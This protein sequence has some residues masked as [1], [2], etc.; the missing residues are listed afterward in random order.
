MPV[1]IILCGSRVLVFKFYFA[2]PV[3][4]PCLLYYCYYCVTRQIN[5]ARESWGINQV[6]SRHSFGGG[7]S[8]LPH[9]SHPQPTRRGLL[10]L[11]PSCPQRVNV[12][13][14]FF[15]FCFY[16]FPIKRFGYSIALHIVYKR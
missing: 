3:Y 5:I 15:F 6:S 16:G 9:H 8:P 13:L 10:L 12:L 1:I 7:I 14:F 2:F 11:S 4:A